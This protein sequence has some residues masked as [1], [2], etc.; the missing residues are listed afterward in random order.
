MK[1]QG[2][3]NDLPSVTK[4]LKSD[5]KTD[6]SSPTT[7]SPL[8]S[9]LLNNPPAVQYRPTLSTASFIPNKTTQGEISSKAFL[10]V[11]CSAFDNVSA[12]F[13]G[14][15]ERLTTEFILLIVVN[16]APTVRV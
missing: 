16:G 9:S 13:Q 8:L 10:L 4:S 15:P 12:L 3:K 7:T 5:N 1:K 14:P 6:G 2:L 11:S